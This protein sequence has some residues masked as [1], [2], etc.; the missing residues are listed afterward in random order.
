[1]LAM[2]ILVPAMLGPAIA[3]GAPQ[4]GREARGKHE[5][6]LQVYLGE[7]RQYTMNRGSGGREALELREKPV[8]VWTNPLRAGGQD[9]AVF[10]WTCRGRAEVIGTIFSNPATGTR[11][12]QHEFHSLAPTSLEVSRRPPAGST[13]ETWS[14]K[15]EGITLAPV[16]GAEAPADT[17]A[18]RLNQMRSLARAFSGTTEDKDGN[19]WELRMLPQPFYRY[20]STVPAVVDGAVFAFVTSAGT[21]PEALL[22]LEARKEP[23]AA[24]PTWQFAAARFTDLSLVM[25]YQGKSAFT[26]PRID[27][28]FGP[29]GSY[30]IF[31]DRVIP[32]VEDG[33]AGADR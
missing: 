12:I 33:V 25:K 11:G 17:P 31:H 10:V 24:G 5:R 21:D 29:S 13:G 20:E 2:L 6:L 23:G 1:M 27:G 8:Y 14:P 19:R 3:G 9:G 30:W 16:P 22:V 18:R 7:V 4:E 32:P 28:P 15:G 26:A